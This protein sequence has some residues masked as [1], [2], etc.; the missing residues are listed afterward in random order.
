MFGLNR[1]PTMPRPGAVKHILAKADRE[2]AEANFRILNI[3]L[4]A[5]ETVLAYITMHDLQMNEPNRK[6][7][8][9]DLEKRTIPDLKLVIESLNKTQGFG[10][11]IPNS[12][13]TCAHKAKA[14]AE[15]LISVCEKGNFNEKGW[16]E[17]TL[18]FEHFAK[19]IEP[20]FE[21]VDRA[22]KQGTHPDVRGDVVDDLYHI[23][24]NPTKDFM[25]HARMAAQ[26]RHN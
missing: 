25:G 26:T 7:C 19:E 6:E 13:L 18:M 3:I 24:M 10:N 15:E 16:T 23:Y 14:L 8:M 17:K 2:V 5:Y 22:F 21:R 4:N 12:L 20:E 11:I 9:K 1:N